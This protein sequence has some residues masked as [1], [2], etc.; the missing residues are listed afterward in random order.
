MVPH[1]G[2]ARGLE[3]T[4]VQKGLEV[5]ASLTQLLGTSLQ[6]VPTAAASSV[7]VSLMVLGLQL[8]AQHLST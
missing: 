5:I 8:A 4:D 7:L 2:G 6:S 1:P 3:I